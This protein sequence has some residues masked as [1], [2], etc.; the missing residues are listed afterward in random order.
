MAVIRF[1]SRVDAK[2]SDRRSDPQIYSS[3]QLF[4]VDVTDGGPNKRPIK[5]A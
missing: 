4:A 2:R 1:T 3:V 5:F